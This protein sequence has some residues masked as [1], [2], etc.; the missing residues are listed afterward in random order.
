MEALKN[1]CERTSR[2][3][4]YISLSNHSQTFV[5]QHAL[6]LV[7]AAVENLFYLLLIKRGSLDVSSGV[8]VV[9]CDCFTG[10]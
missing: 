9:E 5:T 3:N 7:E 6:Y 1:L 4:G 8:F 2:G 10:S